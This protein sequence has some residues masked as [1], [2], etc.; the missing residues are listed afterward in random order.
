MFC[1][2]CGSKIPNDSR[3]CPQC[4]ERIEPSLQQQNIHIA[5]ED[6]FSYKQYVLS[7]FKFHGTLSRKPFIINIFIILSIQGVFWFICSAA[8]GGL[9]SIFA[10]LA[11][12]FTLLSLLA[13][14]VRR[15]RD[16]GCSVI[17]VPIFIALMTFLTTNTIHYSHKMTET[18]RQAE[19]AQNPK[20]EKSSSTSQKGFDLEGFIRDSN[21]R[22]EGRKR[23]KRLRKEADAYSRLCY[24][25]RLSAITS[26]FIFY[27]IFAAL[28]SRKRL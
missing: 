13:L 2:K 9:F 7:L 18:Y 8:D 24:N 19:I 23:S 21:L 26:P 4:G 1:R 5:V 12:L 6:T 15:V 3:F 10:L 28:P 22:K 27:G 14:T 17:F 11:I 25:Y 16:A 20:I